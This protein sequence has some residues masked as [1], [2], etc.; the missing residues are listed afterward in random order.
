MSSYIMKKGN[1]DPDEK[2][3]FADHI[4]GSHENSQCCLASPGFPAPPEGDL[5]T[6]LAAPLS[7]HSMP[8][9]RRNQDFRKV[10]IENPLIAT[11][12]AGYP[13]QWPQ[14]GPHLCAG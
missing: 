4:E 5:S 7:D 3:S 13:S 1:M 6:D 12:E 8:L 9:C 11:L 14:N 2:G 10:F